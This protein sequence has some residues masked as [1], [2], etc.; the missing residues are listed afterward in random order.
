MGIAQRP[1]PVKLITGII[2]SSQAFFNH[3]EKLLVKAFGR[4]DYKSRNIDFNCTEYYAKDMGTGLF[5]VFLSFDMLIDPARLAPVKLIANK[6]EERLARLTRDTLKRPVNIDPGYITA[7]KLILASTKDYSHRIYLDKGIYAETTLIYR[8]KRFA[9][10]DWAYSDY[11]TD[12]C[13]GI[14]TEI[15]DIFMR[16]IGSKE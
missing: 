9:S 14:F 8:D 2:T 11:R 7:A 13:I 3:T 10:C 6:I 1:R 4:L 12:E 5:R 15:R 16:Q